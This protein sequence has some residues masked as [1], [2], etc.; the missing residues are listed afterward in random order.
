M[1]DDQLIAFMTA[2]IFHAKTNQWLQCPESTRDSLDESFQMAVGLLK[3][4]TKEVS[5]PVARSG[6]GDTDPHHFFGSPV[7]PF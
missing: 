6:T 3:R 1:R 4:S 5:A 7:G 2:I